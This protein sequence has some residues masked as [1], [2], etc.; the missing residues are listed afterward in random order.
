MLATMLPF[1]GA[2]GRRIALLSLLLGSAALGLA[3][4][5]IL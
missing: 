5:Q 2:M 1:S 3:A 4:H